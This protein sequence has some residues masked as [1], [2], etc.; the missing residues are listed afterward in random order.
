MPC[1]RSST[2]SGLLK[3]EAGKLDLDAI[4]FD[5]RNHRGMMDVLGKSA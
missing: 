3:I 4:D 2:I 1:S 5:V